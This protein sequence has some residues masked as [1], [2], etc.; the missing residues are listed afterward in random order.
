MI[1]SMFHLRLMMQKL[2]YKKTNFGSDIRSIYYK[3]DL[4]DG[5]HVPKI[6]V[7]LDTLKHNVYTNEGVERAREYAMC[8]F[9]DV[10]K[11]NVL[12]IGLAQKD[13]NDISAKNTIFLEPFKDSYSARQ[14]NDLFKEELKYVKELVKDHKREEAH[15]NASFGNVI[16]SHSPY[17]VYGLVALLIY[18]YFQGFGKDAAMHGISAWTVFKD[19]ESYRLF[20]YILTHGNISHLLGNCLSLYIMGKNYMTRRNAFDFLLV[21][22]ASGVISGVA[23][24]SWSMMVTAEP[25]TRTVGA[26]GAIFALLGAFVTSILMDRGTKGQ[27]QRYVKYAIYVLGINLLLGGAGTDHVCHFAG[28]FTG[29]VIEFM[30]TKADSI[31]ANTR[32]VETRNKKVTSY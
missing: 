26:S 11:D 4:I 32:Y 16:K 6:I 8:Q 9:E 12:V 29:A 17:I 13:Q 15:I 19:G 23:T 3:V 10:P 7:C 20:T 14:V 30:L 22:F 18:L 1:T 25:M 2:R 5:V 24:I 21:F 28:F 27:R 31:Y